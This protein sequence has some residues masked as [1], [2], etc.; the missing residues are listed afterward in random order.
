LGEA[1]PLNLSATIDNSV[2]TNVGVV[3]VN[4]NAGNMNNQTNSLALAVGPDAVYAL[5]EANL[6]QEN[7]HNIIM[8]LNTNKAD[9]ISGSVNGNIGIVQVNQSVGNMNNQASA[10]S[11]SVL[12]SS[13]AISP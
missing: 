9:T 6:G 3:G 13:V 8:E 4:Q 12:T 11:I 5:A 2:N 7:A 1:P 10:F